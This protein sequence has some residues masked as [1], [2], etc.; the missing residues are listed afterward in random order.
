MTF[1]KW[2]SRAEKLKGWLVEFT[3]AF[4]AASDVPLV[5]SVSYGWAESAQCQIDGAYCSQHGVNSEA[6]VKRVNTDFQKIGTA[7]TSI[8]I[9][10]GDAGAASK[11]NMACQNTQTTK[12]L[13][14]KC[15]NM[16][17]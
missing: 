7:G 16:E 3:T 15:V 13:K 6:Y 11:L 5:V 4:M 1:R 8:L 9:A 14:S 2:Y 10:S 12:L 17:Q